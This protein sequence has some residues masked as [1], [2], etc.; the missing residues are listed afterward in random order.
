MAAIADHVIERE[1]TWSYMTLLSEPD[2]VVDVSS[3]NMGDSSVAR[4]TGPLTIFEHARVHETGL[5]IDRPNR[6]VRVRC[7]RRKV[8]G[9]RRGMAELL[10]PPLNVPGG[11]NEWETYERHLNW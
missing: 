3:E 4:R 8:P 2:R 11:L 5:D 10:D 6:R 1:E 9:R 7:S